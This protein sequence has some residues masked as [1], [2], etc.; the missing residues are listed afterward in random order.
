[1]IS[2][3]INTSHGEEKE[4]DPYDLHVLRQRRRSAS[5]SRHSQSK[6]TVPAHPRLGGRA[7]RTPKMRV[8]RLASHGIGERP[9]LP[10]S[11][12]RCLLTD[13]RRF[14]LSGSTTHRVVLQA[15]NYV[16]SDDWAQQNQ[17]GG[18]DQA[19]A[20]PGIEGE[21]VLTLEDDAPVPRQ[22]AIETANL[23]VA[24]SLGLVCGKG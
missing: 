23:D 14:T 13:N 18:V 22:V 5:V 17:R 21:T 3:Q 9:P 20:P 4:I 16:A 1:M 12:R 6:A 11:P 2:Y 19:P 10:C 24:G 7:S 8:P 15:V